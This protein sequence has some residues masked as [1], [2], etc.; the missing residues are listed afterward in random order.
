MVIPIL[1]HQC[2]YGAIG[3]PW[4]REGGAMEREGGAI[5]A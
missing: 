5:G 2:P 3:A 1:N 4:G